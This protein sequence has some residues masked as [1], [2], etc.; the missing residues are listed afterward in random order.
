MKTYKLKKWYPSLHKDWV[1][2]DVAILLERQKY[3]Y[4]IP[5]KSGI[6]FKEEVE[7]NP[8]FWEL[9][10]EK[11]PL[12]TTDDGMKVSNP[13]DWVYLVNSLFEKI[14]RYARNSNINKEIV[15]VFYFEANADE[16]ILMNK[17]V[18]SYNDIKKFQSGGEGIWYDVKAIAKERAG[19][20]K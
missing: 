12:F 20:G 7:N 15:K 9:I 2:G 4:H 13:E 19:N 1:V 14:E 16:Y 8:D 3:Y 11:K 5:N 6:V 18:F 17:P 10:E